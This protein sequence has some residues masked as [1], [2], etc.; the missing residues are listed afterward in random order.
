LLTKLGNHLDHLERVA[1]DRRPSH[2]TDHA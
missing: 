2:S 1:P